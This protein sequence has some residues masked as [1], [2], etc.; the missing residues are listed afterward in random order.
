MKSRVLLCWYVTLSLFNSYYRLFKTGIIAG[1]TLITFILSLEITSSKPKN[2]PSAIIQAN[3]EN[4]SQIFWSN[5]KTIFKNKTFLVL[6][7]GVGSG[8]GLFNCLYNNL[9]PA[10]CSLGYSER[11]IALV[12][13]GMILFG[14]LGSGIISLVVGKWDCTLGSY[15]ACLAIT[16]GNAAA[17]AYLMKQRERQYWLAAFVLGFGFFG[18]PIYPIGLEMAVEDTFPVPEAMTSGFL[19]L[20]G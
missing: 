14:V 9:Q 6:C 4:A 1:L 17:L 8:V 2:P 5:L 13:A 11:Y 15:R 18:F 7:T 12:G 3:S 20:F 10:L 16:A 19:I